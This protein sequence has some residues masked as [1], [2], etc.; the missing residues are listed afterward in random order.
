MEEPAFSHADF[1]QRDTECRYN[2]S[3]LRQHVD[4]WGIMSQ[5]V[6]E[7][8]LAKL[9]LWTE[10][11]RDPIDMGASDEDVIR[12]AIDNQS[13]NWN[14]DKMLVDIGG[15]YYFNE[16]PTVVELKHD[17]YVVYDGN[18]RV[19]VLKCIQDQ[20]LY[21]AA[22]SKLPTFVAPEALL[23]QTVL[24]CNVCDVETALD[25]VEKYHRGSGKWG[26]LQYE[27]FLH[28]HRGG[29]KGRL[30]L[31]DEAT[32][33]LVSENPNLNQEYVQQRL[34]TDRNLES[35]G[36]SVIDGELVTNHDSDEEAVGILEDIGRVMD[37]KLTNA[38]K[39]PGQ[40]RAALEEMDPEK[41]RDVKPFSSE[42]R[43]RTVRP[44][45]RNSGRSSVKKVPIRR[46]GSGPLFG[47]TIRP[48][49]DQSN[50]IYAGIE[51][52]YS[53]Y[54]KDV[55]GRAYLL[56][57]LGF[58]LRLFL[59]TVAREYYLAQNPPVDKGD[60][61]LAVF[62]KDVIKPL[63]R[64]REESMM[65]NQDALTAQLIDRRDNLEAILNK[66]AHGTL[67]VDEEIL[68]RE[69]KI[70]AYIVKEVWWRD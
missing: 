9:H 47:E 33:G 29:Q 56:P 11:P 2:E 63:L 52:I 39:N 5:V 17:E 21:M 51:H 12:R 35:I 38:R 36:F 49:G 19:A 65:L 37:Q 66:W 40:L 61:A 58:S 16:L 48:R 8:P 31:L 60:D 41:Y 55:N 22:T 23:Q 68:L 44:I 7:I 53:E 24:P 64:K 70:V 27:Y 6:R 28:T 25:I 20:N 1:S 62:H 26:K 59:E 67:D 14:L 34:L 3:D 69:S 18:R 43:S 46:K 10:N 54:K 57:I 30:M 13:G 45:A 32:G 42:G 4:D 15:L 50:L